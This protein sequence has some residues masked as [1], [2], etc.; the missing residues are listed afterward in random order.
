MPFDYDLFII[1]AGPGGT[2]AARR[3]ADCGAKVAIAEKDRVGGTCV[4][5]GCVPEKMMTYAARYADLLKNADEY[6]WKD[7]SRFFS[8]P[9]FMRIRD[10]NIDHLVEVHTSH[11]KEAEVTLLQGEAR[12]VDSHTVSVKG[13]GEISAERVLIAVG[14]HSVTP[15]IEGIEH[16]ILMRDLLAL[17]KAPN[18]VVIVGSNH[19]ATKFAGILNGLSCHV[20]Q[21]FEEATVLPQCDEDLR[22]VIAQEMEEEGITLLG[23][24]QVQRITQTENGLMLQ[25][26]GEENCELQVDEVIFATDR[27]ATIDN[28]NLE[29]VGV[30]VECG[31]IAVDENNCTSVDHIY[32]IGDCTLSPQWTPVAIA[33][34]HAFA[35]N[36]FDNKQKRVSYQSI[37]YGVSTRPEAA[38]IGLTE[39]QAK[40][41]LNGAVQCYQKTF[42]PL[43]NLMGESKREALLKLVVD[44][45]TDEVIGAH[46]VGDSA[47]EVVQMIAPA[48]KAG[49][50]MKH[51]GRSLGIH[52]T[53]SEEFFTM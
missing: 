28:L 41:K 25:L 47:T 1:G 42:E 23:R 26:K 7:V 27:A 5:H 44:E 53:I 37:P 24:T 12:F 15:E 36:V 2:A 30:A 31:A 50:K 3:A 34:G 33:Q 11:L 39:V 40:D 14:A 22:E 19:I 21:I 29:A 6:G 38:T 51:F 45:E 20:I 32:A 46:M 9:Q 13:H 4:V 35:E 43:F 17:D 16:A 10:N 49:V 8:W 18:K 48:M 52:P